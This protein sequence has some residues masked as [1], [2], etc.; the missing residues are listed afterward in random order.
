MDHPAQLNILDCCAYALASESGEALLFKGDPFDRILVAQ[1]MSEASPLITKDPQ[2]SQY[3][4][5][6]IW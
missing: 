5:A 3:G 2:L 1:S 4:I 6:T